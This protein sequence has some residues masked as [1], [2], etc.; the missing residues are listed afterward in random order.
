M[1]FYEIGRLD[2]LAGVKTYTARIK[3]LRE[4]E[5]VMAGFGFQCISGGEYSRVFENLKRGQVVKVYNDECYDRFIRFCKSNPSNP[6]LPRFRGN[7]IKVRAD[8]RMISIERLQPMTYDEIIASGVWRLLEIAK[9][10]SDDGVQWDIP[11]DM[12]PLFE[13]L[14]QLVATAGPCW[15]DINAGNVMKRGNQLVIIDPYAPDRDGWASTHR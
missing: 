11:E 14:K 13:T 12:Q 9:N 10:P 3:N 5:E 15:I 7:S 8:A 1:R 4:L 2:E 6:Y